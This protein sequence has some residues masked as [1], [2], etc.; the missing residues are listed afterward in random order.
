[1]G[2]TGTTIDGNRFTNCG[3]SNVMARP[4]LNIWSGNVLDN[5]VVQN[6]AVTP[7]TLGGNVVFLGGPTDTCGHIVARGNVSS[8]ALSSFACGHYTSLQVL[9]NSMVMNMPT[10]HAVLAKP[11]VYF[12]GNLAPVG[13]AC[14]SGTGGTTGGAEG[15]IATAAPTAPTTTTPIG[16]DT[17]PAAPAPAS[18]TWDVLRQRRLVALDQP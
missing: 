9:G 17:A 10:C 16:A 6:N 8:T 11:N 15:P 7:P 2:T 18:V 5:V 3:Y 12:A 14:N 4:Q 1:M 13:V